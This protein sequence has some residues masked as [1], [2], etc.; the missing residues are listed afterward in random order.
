MAPGLVVGLNKG[1]TLTKR[2]LPERP[3]RRKGHLS[4]R[5]AFVRSIV[6]EVAGF[7]PYERRVMELIRNSQDKRAR[8][9]AKKR[10]GTLKRAKGKIEELTSVIQSSRLAH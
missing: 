5:T 8:K 3:S 6:R 7:A 4:K 2:Q 9:L 1:K 10:L